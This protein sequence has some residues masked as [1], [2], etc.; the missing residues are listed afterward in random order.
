[1]RD[2]HP[3]AQARDR[4]AFSVVSST[5]AA[6]LARHRV[7]RALEARGLDGAGRTAALVVSELV[8]NAVVHT[9]SPRVEVEVEERGECV[10]V[11]VSDESPTVPML[12]TRTSLGD[13]GLGLSIVNRLSEGIGCTRH[14]S[15]G[16]TVWSLF[17]R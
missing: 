1:M 3:S 15:G 5:T 14:S 8:T 16:K 12:P 13:G 2:S 6:R 10:W 9:D 7:Q 17:R 11:G 4:I